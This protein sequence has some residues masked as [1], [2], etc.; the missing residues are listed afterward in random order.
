LSLLATFVL[1][2][3]I[4]TVYPTLPSVT[5]LN[6]LELQIPLRIYSKNG[7][8]IGE[9]GSKRRT[10][11][12]YHNIPEQLIYAFLSAEDDSF[13]S[14]YGVS[15]IGLSRGF[16]QILTSGR[17]Q[18]GGSTITMQLARNLFLTPEKSLIRKFKEIL[19]AFK[20]ENQL[21]KAEILEIYLNKIYL[22]KRA[23][24][25]EAA[26][27]VYYNKTL[28]E[29]NLA[30]LAMIAGLPK[31]PSRFN[32]IINPSRALER[33]NWI[34]GRML[35]LGYISSADYNKNII[36]PITAFDHGAKLTYET[37]YINEMVRQDLFEQ[38]GS[39][40][41]T[42]GY[43]VYTTIDLSLQQSADRAV[44]TGIL[45]YEMRHGYRGP[46]KRYQGYQTSTVI[47]DDTTANNPTSEPIASNQSSSKVL[48]LQNGRTLTLVT[49]GAS[50]TIV[51]NNGRTWQLSPNETLTI[52][53]DGIIQK[54][55]INQKSQLELYQKNQ[56]LFAEI[57]K[58]IDNPF[59]VNLQDKP[60]YY[61]LQNQA[62]ELSKQFLELETKIHNHYLSAQS[63]QFLFDW[64]EL[65]Q[66]EAVIANSLQPAVVIDVQEKQMRI[67]LKSSRLITIGWSEQ[68]ENLKLYK[69]ADVPKETAIQS[70]TEAFAVGDVIYVVKDDDNYQVSQLPEVQGALISLNPNSGAIQS[71]MGG[72]DF[73]FNKFNRAVQAIRQPGSSIKPFIYATALNHKF[74]PATLINDAAITFYDP[75]L[76]D[77]WR[78]DNYTDKFYGPTTM[79]RALFL[80]LNLVSIRVLRNLGIRKGI[81]GL[82]K[83][84]FEENKLP[85]DLTLS[86]GT[87]PLTPLQL[88]RAY[89][90]LANGGH[91]VEPYIIDKV[92]LRDDQVL[93][94]K[95]LPNLANSE[96]IVDPRII[97]IIDD[98]LKDAVKKG[99]ARKARV[100]QRNDIAGKTGT[101]N[102][103]R[104][105]WFAGYH[106]DLVAVV[107]MGFDKNNVLGRYESGGTAALPIWIDYMRDA[108]Q[109][110]PRKY[111]T[112]PKGLVRL[113]INKFTGELTTSTDPNFIFE[114]FLEESVP[115]QA[116]FNNQE[117]LIPKN[118]QPRTTNNE[119]Q[120]NKIF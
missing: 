79:R 44:R 32:P 92:V 53:S 27:N 108:L 94:Q 19:L 105:L 95:Q 49:K 111:P 78:P 61:G 102:G 110:Y 116:K 56:D 47:V 112:Q 15:I 54:F 96:P 86:L 51:L 69:N 77:I 101:T 82:V 38:Y 24:G 26:A 100:L 97:Y 119:S 21:T 83:F 68:L 91:I 25:I 87:Q 30:Q 60:D 36:Q 55:K 17:I 11:V 118:S 14:H 3:W 4:L 34:L 63:S 88:A 57:A 120:S 65:L 8:L 80:S 85:R 6:E 7:E 16:Y 81:D 59:Q 10:P 22:G 40:I 62:D 52:V 71:L 2:M 64:L 5:R 93:F 45:D 74:T 41:Y 13:F 9:F 90:M 67:M 33:R 113:R 46:Y 28:Q 75:L 72:L 42:E 35:S 1:A 84:G 99:T 50:H 18:S 73:Y 20:I 23:Y 48:A 114:Y 109:K 98:I 31:A 29:L 66:D 37:G 76:E 115:S 103:P 104:D 39:E 43:K 58:V 89:A 70:A 106:Q 117:T 12:D 107:W